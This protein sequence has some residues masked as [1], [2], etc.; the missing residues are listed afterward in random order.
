MSPRAPDESLPALLVRHREALARLIAKEGQGLLR[1]EAAEDLVQG[2]CEHALRVAAHFEYRGEAP[3]LAWLREVARRHVADRHRYWTSLKRGSARVVRLTSRGVSSSGLRGEPL[4]FATATGPS[5]FA[6][7]REQ[8]ALAVRAL[9]LL[10]ERDRQ[11]VRWMSEDVPVHEQARRFELSEEST[12]RAG[13]RALDRF[14]KTFQAIAG[15]GRPP[16]RA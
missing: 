8:L 4:P 10:S 5:T 12:R 3:F 11:L 16:P 9:A 14:R 15:S 13:T 2:A 6:V 7:R 1:L